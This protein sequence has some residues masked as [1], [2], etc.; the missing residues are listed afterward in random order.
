MPLGGDV[1]LGCAA[2]KL[3][4]RKSQ[5]AISNGLPA[6]FCPLAALNNHKEIFSDPSPRKPTTLFFGHLTPGGRAWAD[7]PFAAPPGGNGTDILGTDPILGSP[8]HPVIRRQI[9]QRNGQRKSPARMASER[10]PATEHWLGL[11]EGAAPPECRRAIP[12]G[13]DSSAQRGWCDS[14]KRRSG[15]GDPH[16]GV[17]VYFAHRIFLDFGSICL[18]ARTWKL[19]PSGE[20]QWP[21]GCQIKCRAR[22]QRRA[23]NDDLRWVGLGANS[24]SFTGLM[25]RSL[26]ARGVRR[27]AI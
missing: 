17:A 2:T 15:R 10:P 23:R 16:P 3:E 14:G 27:M 6:K 5:H 1:S 20:A 25:C 22:L 13:S 18:Y 19:V 24:A 8:F 4:R 21:P 26:N 12:F 7:H 9:G 11:R